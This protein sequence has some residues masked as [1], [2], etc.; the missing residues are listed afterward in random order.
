VDNLIIQVVNRYK[1]ITV[2]VFFL[3][4]LNGWVSISPIVQHGVVWQV[5]VAFVLGFLA[6]I[7]STFLLTNRT[8][9]N[10]S[11]KGESFDTFIFWLTGWILII[12]FSAFSVSIYTSNNFLIYQINLVWSFFML[13]YL[14][15]GMLTYLLNY[16]VWERKN[17]RTLYSD[18]KKIYSYPYIL[19]K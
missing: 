16:Q 3:S 10:I 13:P 14:T 18:Y 9:K 2:G 12:V 17:K 19:T 15:M 7:A 6:G 8:L 5:A 4:L 1:L 11:K